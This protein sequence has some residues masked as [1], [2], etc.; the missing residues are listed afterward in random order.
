[1]QGIEKYK[2]RLDIPV[3]WGD[4]DALD[5]VNNA[6]Y[7]GWNED[8]RIAYFMESINNLS[9]D[10]VGPILARQDIKYIYPVTFPDTVTVGI[11]V[12]EV[13]EDRLIFETKMWSD[14]SQKLVAL[15]HSTVMAY[16]VAKKTKASIPQVWLD[17]IKE[18]EG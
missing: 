9:V 5:H 7:I 3:R 2:V 1:M 14:K 17:K 16:D 15:V 11:R 8:A 6:V 4:M 12:S 18:I 10:N 13:L